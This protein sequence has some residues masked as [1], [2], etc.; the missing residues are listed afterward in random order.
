L[1]NIF[2]T[3]GWKWSVERRLDILQSVYDMVKTDSNERLMNTQN[4]LIIAVCVVL[5]LLQILQAF[6]AR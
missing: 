2:N 3:D 1:C 4:N 5:P 6:F